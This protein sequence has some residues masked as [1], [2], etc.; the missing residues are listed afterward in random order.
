V[1]ILGTHVMLGPVTLFCDR[2]YVAPE[3]LVALRKQ[4]ECAKDDDTI[5]I[6]FTPFEDCTIEARY[7]HWLPDDEAEAIRQ[8]P[9]YQCNYVRSYEDVWML[10]TP[11]V[12]EAVS[13]LKSWYDEDVAEQKASWQS[14]KIA[15]EQDRISDRKLFP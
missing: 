1:V 10:P 9:M 4:L 13:L 7:I 6:R 3:D 5:K 8:L 11:D 2:T 15:L 12:D 14:L